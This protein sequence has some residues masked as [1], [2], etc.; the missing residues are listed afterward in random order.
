MNKFYQQAIELLECGFQMSFCG[1]KLLQMKEMLE[2]QD[3]VVEMLVDS[4]EKINKANINH[5]H[6]SINRFPS[7][8]KH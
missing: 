4:Y 2:E 1:Q 6:L 3:L 8:K 7:D 5:L